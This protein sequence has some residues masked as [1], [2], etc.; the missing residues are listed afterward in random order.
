MKSLSNWVYI[1]HIAHQMFCRCTFRTTWSPCV[2]REGQYLCCASCS[3]VL[4]W[5]RLKLAHLLVVLTAANTAAHR[6]LWYAVWAL[7]K[8]KATYQSFHIV[9]TSQSTSLL[10]DTFVYITATNYSGKALL[11]RWQS[12]IELKEYKAIDSEHCSI[13]TLTV[14][15]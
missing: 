15:I 12:K 1:P 8:H 3:D 5:L 6:A 2:W 7:T 10:R 11:I 14:L 13:F 9:L 4:C